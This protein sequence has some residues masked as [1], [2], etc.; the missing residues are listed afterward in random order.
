MDYDLISVDDHVIEPP[1]VWVDRLPAKYR[2]DGPHVVEDGDRQYWVYEGR[3]GETMGLN[4]VAG[5]EYKEFSMDPVRY[6]D[7]IEGCYNPVQ[8]A[9]DLIADGVRGSLCFPTFPRFAGVTFLKSDDKVLADLCVKAYNDWMLEEWCA[10]VPGM[11]I[12][13]I[14]GQ[15]WDPKAMAAEIRRC[16]AKGARAVTFPENPVPVGLPSL[17]TDF[18][19]PIWEAVTETDIAVCSHIGTS[20]VNLQPASDSPFIM[21]ISLSP[22]AAWST[23]TD[24]VMGHIPRKFPTIRWALS[25]G[26]IGWVPFALERSDRSWERHRHWSGLDDLLPSEIFKRNVWVCFINESIGIEARHRIGIDKIMW[27]CDYPHADTPWPHSQKE[28]D[29]SLHGLPADEVALMTHGNAE[30]VFR[31]TERPDVDKLLGTNV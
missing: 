28:V 14:I 21:S 27:E 25:E 9:K 2:E 15:L 1:N 18:Y 17:S 29:E 5:K 10:S 30:R 26:G 11:Y 22:M 3:R 16:A 19:D 4:A 24:I 13:M 23:F 12:P 31:W 7:M 8:R 20:G 6:S